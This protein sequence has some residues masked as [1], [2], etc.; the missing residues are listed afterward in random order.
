MDDGNQ[1][2]S[3]ILIIVLL[4]FAVFFAVTETAFA[5]ASRI[6]IKNAADRGEQGAA[7]ALYILDNFD[8]AISTILIGTNIVHI[9]VASIV[10]VLV[11]KTWGMGYV[12]VSTIVTTLVV[13][14]VGEMLP[15]SI[16]KKYPERFSKMFAK[17]LRFFMVIFR[18][19]A[20]LLTW[21][22]QTA[23][24]LSGGE[25]EVSFT[26]DELYDIIDDMEEE[27]TLNEAQSDL[28]ASALQ[29]GDVTVESI[30]TPRVDVAAVNVDTPVNEILNTVRSY[31]HSRFPVY[32]GS[33][34]TVIGVLQIRTFLKAY[35]KQGDSLNIR[36]I[37]DDVLFVHQSTNIDELLPE[38]SKHKTNLA[39][40]TDNYG[41]TLGI[42][43]VENILEELVGE[44][45]DEDDIVEEPI[46]DLTDGTCIV[47][48]SETV[49][50]LLEHMD[51]EEYEEDENE[52]FI[53]TLMGEW[54]YEQ[55][56]TIPKFGDSFTYKRL[57]VTVASINHNRI[58]KLKVVRLPEEEKEEK[59]EKSLIEKLKGDDSE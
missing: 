57:E 38:M 25:E 42:V 40:V 4:G 17:P 27:G 8:R 44:I 32:E 16:G 49:G 23:A 6:R 21:I 11:T 15:K 5:S 24:K 36:D 39:V 30:L 3:W 43:T 1:L 50:D 37:L 53:N 28:I 31:S 41:G 35:M 14:F 56:N 2:S 51:L 34:D 45:W 47:D 10:T 18:P 9:S 19:L 33:I 52:D 13:F 46:I 22:G 54:A 12:T 29:F 59:E 20:A 55:F 26:E 48:A 58:R 7:D